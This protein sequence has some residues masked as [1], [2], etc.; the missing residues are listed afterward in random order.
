MCGRAVAC[1]EKE[2]CANA[3]SRCKKEA[4]HADVPRPARYRLQTDYRCTLRPPPNSGTSPAGTSL[5]AKSRPQYHRCHSRSVSTPST[6]API[7]Q[8][9]I[10][11]PRQ[12]RSALRFCCHF[13][14]P[15]PL[16]VHRRVGMSAGRPSECPSALSFYCQNHRLNTRRTSPSSQ[17]PPSLP[18]TT[19]RHPPHKNRS[20]RPLRIVPMLNNV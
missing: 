15:L 12:G 20:G 9:I 3:I 5:P 1:R 17:R 4:T 16:T 11:Q 19:A 2:G 18:N 8:P 6:A 13:L 10:P 7:S 14:F